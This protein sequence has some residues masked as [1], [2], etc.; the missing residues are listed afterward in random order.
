MQPSSFEIPSLVYFFCPVTLLPSNIISCRQTSLA[1]A[2][3]FFAILCSFCIKKT[4]RSSRRVLFCL[5]S[6]RFVNLKAF[7]LVLQVFVLQRLVYISSLNTLV[8]SKSMVL[9]HT[10]F[11]VDFSNSMQMV[12]FFALGSCL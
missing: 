2:L 7:N 5:S 4:T 12:R 9:R 1:G 10:K 6:E 8:Y 3:G 11:T